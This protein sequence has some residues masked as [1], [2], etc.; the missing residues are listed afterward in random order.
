MAPEYQ[1]TPGQLTPNR[2]ISTDSPLVELDNLITL[3]RHWYDL[4]R[5]QAIEEIRK[6]AQ[7]IRS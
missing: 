6:D 2:L 3:Y 7:S 1:L 4:T 5:N